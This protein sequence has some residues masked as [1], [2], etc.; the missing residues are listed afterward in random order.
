[1]TYQHA[2]HHTA[3][4]RFILHVDSEC[5]FANVISE[6]VTP[7]TSLQGILGTSSVA[8]GIQEKSGKGLSSILPLES[9]VMRHTMILAISIVCF[10]QMGILLIE[11][12]CDLNIRNWPSDSDGLGQGRRGSVEGKKEEKKKKEKKKG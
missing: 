10:V 9:P 2:A 1:M 8:Q 12:C 7:T 11:R 5:A 6:G 4:C 3:C